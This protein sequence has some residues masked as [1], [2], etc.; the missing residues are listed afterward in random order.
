MMVEAKGHVDENGNLTVETV[1]TPLPLPPGDVRVI[2]PS[3]A[4]ACD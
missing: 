4:Q 1:E 2:T 3:S